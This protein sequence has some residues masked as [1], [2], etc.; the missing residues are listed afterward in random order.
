MRHI[1]K[2]VTQCKENELI[3]TTVVFVSYFLFVLSYRNTSFRSSVCVHV[4]RVCDMY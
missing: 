2:T 4:C 3:A 1:L